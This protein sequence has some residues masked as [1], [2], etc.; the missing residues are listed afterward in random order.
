MKS[1]GQFDVLHVAG[2]VKERVWRWSKMDTDQI[3]GA[4]SMSVCDVEERAFQ[5][6][7]SVRL[8]VKSIPRTLAN[9]EDCR[10]LVSASGCAGA[11]YIEANEAIDKKDFIVRTKI[12]RK[13]VKESQYW[14][15]LINETND[16][17]NSGEAR[18]LIEEA[19]ELEK[20]FSSII[21]KSK[22]KLRAR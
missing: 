1:L 20:V 3:Q 4:E 11:N 2:S 16:L 17:E 15:R 8:F 18:T 22:W 21:D 13:K 14:L 5:F 19:E 12:S 7:K 9:V 6:S 10:Q